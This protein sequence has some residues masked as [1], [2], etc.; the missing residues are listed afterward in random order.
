MDTFEQTLFLDKSAS[1][2]K[3]YLGNLRRLNNGKEIKSVTFLKDLE[4]N[5]KFIENYGNPGTRKAYY[6]SAVALLTGNKSYKKQYDIYHLKMMDLLKSLNDRPHKS[7]STLE[8]CA[9]PMDD[10]LQRQK[11]LY[12]KINFKILKKN[13]T[14]SILDDLQDTIIVSLYTLMP[15]RRNADYTEMKIGEPKDDNY[16]YYDKF[17]FYFNR[18][19]TDKIYGQQVVD[20]PDEIG[21]LIQLRQRLNQ[22]EWLLTNTR[23]DK[24]SSQLMTK[25]VADSF[26]MDV[27]ASAI[28]NISATD[29][30]GGQK[31]EMQKV[32]TEMGT[33][34]AMLAKIYIN[35]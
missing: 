8:K 9:I 5:I 14:Q 33:S 11:E 31:V 15:P 32:A 22:S 34:V 29:K 4:K 20:V 30:F 2:K 10:L 6:A 35:N 24:L 3:N 26:G 23:G 25:Y 13:V 21:K 17:K 27:G 12:S 28:R 1:T 16:N 19:K 7:E 18:Y